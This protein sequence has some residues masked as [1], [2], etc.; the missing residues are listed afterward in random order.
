[1]CRSQTA[2]KAAQNPQMSLG[3]R[4][5][6]SVDSK[7]RLSGSAVLASTPSHCRSTS[8]SGCVLE[9]RP[10][11]CYPCT[12][13]NGPLPDPS[14]HP[15]NKYLLITDSLPNSA[16]GVGVEQDQNRCRPGSVWAVQGYEVAKAGLAFKRQCEQRGPSHEESL[17]TR[18]SS[19]AK[20]RRMSRI[21]VMG[22]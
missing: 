14:I 10:V 20:S 7:R 3:C 22:E 21:K 19:N 17:C 11:G 18:R 5:G 9:E 1:M 15:L 13:D 4:E 12:P 6:D 2:V 16:L 8:L